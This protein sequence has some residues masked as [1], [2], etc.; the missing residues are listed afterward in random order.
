MVQLANGN[1]DFLMSCVR[2]L[3]VSPERIEKS[4]A[5]LRGNLVS[6]FLIGPE[7][8]AVTY[9]THHPSVLALPRISIVLCLDTRE[10][11]LDD[12]ARKI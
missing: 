11:S 4:A 2:A 3:R 1:L 10:I 8:C 12:W 9:R 5:N 7:A 6:D